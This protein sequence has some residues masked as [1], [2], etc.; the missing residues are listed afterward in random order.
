MDRSAVDSIRE[1]LNIVEVI[2]E[3]V[4]SLKKAGRSYK[5]CC[6]FHKE[7]TPSFHVDEDKQLFYCFGCQTGGDVFAFVMKIENISFAEAGEK[8]AEKAG[9]DWRPQA[10]AGPAE[11]ERADIKRAIDFAVR[12]YQTALKS[13]KYAEHARKYLEGRSLSAAMLEKFR[14]GYAHTEPDSFI[15][16][17]R[18]EGFS[19]STLLKAGLMGRGEGGRVWDYFRGR[20]LFPIQN[21]RGDSV[22]FGGR[23]LDDREPKYLNSP[24]TP[25]FSKGQVLFGL[26]QGAQAVRRAGVL[27][28]C[29]GYMDVIACHQAGVENA[30]APLGT[31]FGPDHA[32]LIKRYCQQVVLLFDPDPAGVRAALRAAP[33]LITG[34]LQVKVASLGGGLDPDEFLQERGREAFDAVIAGAR[35]IIEFHADVVMAALPHPVSSH[36]KARAA[37]EL[38]PTALVQPNPIVR[39]DWIRIIADRLS[40]SEAVL[41]QRASSPAIAAAAGPAREEEGPARARPD[42]GIPPPERELLRMVVRTPAFATVCGK[43]LEGVA[44]SPKVSSL[45]SAM[46][47]VCEGGCPDAEVISSLCAE[48]PEYEGLVQMLAVEPEPAS[49]LS[50][51]GEK[52]PEGEAARAARAEEEMAGR[53]RAFEELCRRIRRTGLERR[54]AELRAS[55]AELGRKGQDTRDIQTQLQNIAATL[56]GSGKI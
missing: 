20:V 2:R 18:G 3:Y 23:V 44:L 12:Y 39:A 41:R 10:P 24:E 53:M 6:P 32:R 11:A 25:V 51:T 48:K 17:A 21:H 45:L 26:S 33:I 22:A 14:I 56:K 28:V 30:A 52:E 55:L 7:K 47:K 42:E 43:L 15:K 5:A 50:G 38:L 1:R 4:P 34:G 40:I 29:E 8:L 16:A 31:A 36:D 13:A 49:R 37:D 46:N 54:Q 19:D 27:I 9:V 35:D